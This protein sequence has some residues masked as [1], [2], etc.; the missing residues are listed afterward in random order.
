MIYESRSLTAGHLWPRSHRS[1]AIVPSRLHRGGL[2]RRSPCR[3]RPPSPEHG[4]VSIR[5]RVGLSRKAQQLSNSPG[6]SGYV[7]PPWAPLSLLHAGSN[8]VPRSSRFI[9]ASVLTATAVLSHVSPW[10]LLL[11]LTRSL[12]TCDARCNL[13]FYAYSARVTFHSSTPI[14]RGE[15][16]EAPPRFTSIPE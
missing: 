7:A 10:I 1:R 14:V 3:P 13:I 9:R 15:L 5:R 16:I 11:K 4:K 2:F 8:V 12:N 6:S